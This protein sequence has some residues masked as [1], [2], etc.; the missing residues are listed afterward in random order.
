MS[1]CELVYY[2]C[3]LRD[4]LTSR[5]QAL[6]SK[7]HSIDQNK[8]CLINLCLSLFQTKNKYMPLF[9]LFIQQLS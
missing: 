9:L 4:D 2:T 7:E 8:V 6:E 1:K 3:H 5:L